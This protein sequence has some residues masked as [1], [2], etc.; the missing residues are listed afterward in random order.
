MDGVLFCGSCG[1]Q[2]ASQT[3][4][5]PEEPQQ[6]W[7]QP[8]Q[9]PQQQPAG[10]GNHPAGGGYQ[11]YGSPSSGGMVPPKNYMTEA[12]LVT[13]ISLCCCCSLIS[14]VLGIIAIV[15]A[16]NVNPAFAGGN[17]NEA[18]SSAASAK[19]LTIWAAVISV[20]FAIIYTLFYVFIFAAAINE[21]GGV[22]EF[23]NH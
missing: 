18:I 4:P 6:S 10:Y 12:I 21:A 8:Y 3:P 9:Q 11:A 17:Y 5:L 22:Q 7:Q 14:V 1:A 23:F 20:V 16:N 19:N 13:V 2:M 15:K